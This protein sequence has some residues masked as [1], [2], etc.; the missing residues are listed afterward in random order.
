[1]VFV[2]SRA[3]DEAHAESS[4]EAGNGRADDLAAQ[5][6]FE[7]PQDGVVV[8]SAAL[9]DDV[10][11]ELGRVFDLDDFIQ[12]IL[13]DRVREACRDVGQRSPFF[14][15][16]LDFGVHEDRAARAQVDRAL[17]QEGGLREVLNGH[18]QGFGER[19]QERTA[20]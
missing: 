15:S 4:H 20:A 5:E 2:V 18:F 14:L 1:M 9:D 6:L 12:G 19:I 8:E 10:L 13:D 16:L 3:A 11:A 17:G 7:S